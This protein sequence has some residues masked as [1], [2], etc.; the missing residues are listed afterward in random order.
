MK[1]RQKTELWILVAIVAASFCF[2]PTVNMSYEVVVQKQ[3]SEEYTTI[4]PYTVLEQVRE[5]YTVYESYIGDYGIPNERPVTQWRIVTK[6]VTKY[7]EVTKTRLV[8]RPLVETQ[9][10]RV[11]LLRYLLR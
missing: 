6:E 8:T 10:K 11:S 7:R 1:Q 9:T 5:P 3:V 2:V 4:E